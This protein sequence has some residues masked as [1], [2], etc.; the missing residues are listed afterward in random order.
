MN[1]RKSLLT[2][3]FFAFFSLIVQANTQEI[4][5]HPRVVELE[6]RLNK[7]ASGYIK[8]RFPEIPY[9]VTVR[10]DPLRRDVKSEYS[11]DRDS[12]PYFDVDEQEEIKDEWDNPQVPLMALINRSKRIKVTISVPSKLKE[13][14]V[15]EL[16]E[17]IFSVIHLTPARDEI[18]I[19]RRDWVT[20][21]VPWT[22]VYITAGILFS[23]LLGLL[24][25]NRTSANRIAR[26]LTDIKL[27]GS[28]QPSHSPAPSA[29]SLNLDLESRSNRKTESQEVKFNDPIK[30]KELATRHIQFLMGS[31]NFPNHQDI[32][33]LDKLG[34]ENPE[35]LGAILLEFPAE[36]QRKLF[37]YSSGF[38]WIEALHEP[39][40][41]DFECLEILQALTQ[42]PRE[43]DD[44]EWDHAVLSV[45]R[46]GEHRT[47]FIKSLPKDEA[48]ALLVDMPKAVAVSEA[49]KAF[50]GSWAALLDPDFS[51]PH[52]S[53]SR[54]QEIQAS[55]VR[56][57]PLNDIE[58]VRRYRAEK[59]LLEFLTTSSP[60]EERDIYG[61]AP[62][63]SLIHTLRPPFYPVFEQSQE[64]LQ[65]FVQKISTDHWALAL[66]NL[67]KPDRSKIDEHFSEKQKFL[68]IEKFKRFDSQP[69]GSIKVGEAREFVG[70]AL[71][72]FLKEKANADKVNS[73][74]INISDKR[75]DG[76]SSKAA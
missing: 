64:L 48:F 26:A 63:H 65:W 14:E 73:E 9:M 61:A 39:G 71:A 58:L 67:P 70:R 68:L 5:K 49:R 54:V 46:L 36:M 20:E 41:L 59:E 25:I 66:F 23:L 47:Q 60:S 6:D 28:N 40:F 13:A 56:L 33:V 35:K 34:Q 3:S 16:K 37:S 76:N 1:S 51:P 32:F 10:V 18:E 31:S 43:R 4:L 52:L 19:L 12:L 69:P 24:V 27:G 29:Q 50:P 42:N 53:K 15:S 11:H 22:S 38:Y 45:W 55:A 57:L 7:D 74:I 44:L 75:S 30:M 2:L 62:N 72:Q 17:G 8:S 21:E